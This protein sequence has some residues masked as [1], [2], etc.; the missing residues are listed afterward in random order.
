MDFRPGL[1]MDFRCDSDVSHLDLQLAVVR[2]RK[3]MPSIHDLSSRKL[4]ILLSPQIVPPACVLDCFSFD[5]NVISDLRIPNA[6]RS[7]RQNLLFG[8]VRGSSHHTHVSRGQ[9]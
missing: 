8:M 5:Y 4:T 1:P 7:R 3:N 2:N 9:K 6:E